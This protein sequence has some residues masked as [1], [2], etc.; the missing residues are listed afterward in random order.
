MPDLKMSSFIYQQAETLGN[1]G[2]VASQ[3]SEKLFQAEAYNEVNTFSPQLQVAASD[4]FDYIKGELGKNNFSL[5]DQKNPLIG[6]KTVG[7][8]VGASSEWYSEQV[9]WIDSNVKNPDARRQLKA[10]LNQRS[11]ELELKVKDEFDNTRIDNIGANLQKSLGDHALSPESL[12]V[13]I[14]KSAADISTAVATNAISATQGEALFQ[15]QRITL[16]NNGLADLQTFIANI[17]NGNATYDQNMATGKL[18]LDEL[19]KNGVDPSKLTILE[20]NLQNIA[21]ETEV[22]NAA[23]DIGMEGGESA[24]VSY[25]YSQTGI[26]NTTKR[27]IKQNAWMAVSDQRTAVGNEFENKYLGQLNEVLNTKDDKGAPLTSSQLYFK[28]K[29]LRQSASKEATA[30]KIPGAYAANMDKVLE[31]RETFYLG[32]MQT[33]N[34]TAFIKEWNPKTSNYLSMLNNGKDD[35]GNIVDPATLADTIERDIQTLEQD[36]TDYGNA[37]PNMEAID[38]LRG[39]QKNAA[40]RAQNNNAAYYAKS[41]TDARLAAQEDVGNALGTIDTALAKL[42]T[43]PH[44]AADPA[45]RENVRAMLSKTK[46]GLLE[47]RTSDEAIGIVNNLY[48]KQ[49]SVQDLIAMGNWNG[50]MTA[51]SALESSMNEAR[52]AGKPL[53]ASVRDNFDKNIATMKELVRQ[54][55]QM[56]PLYDSW[57]SAQEAVELDKDDAGTK[58][59]AF[60]QVIK[61]T[62]W[63]TVG[64]REWADKA[65]LSMKG[66][67]QEKA[68]ARVETTAMENVSQA[69]F[70]AAEAIIANAPDAEEKLKAYSNVIAST[71]WKTPSAKAAAQT[72]YLNMKESVVALKKGTADNATVKA[73]TENDFAYLKLIRGWDDSAD[74]M[75]SISQIDEKLTALE[76]PERG[77]YATDKAAVAILQTLSQLKSDL[78]TRYANQQVISEKDK[79]AAHKRADENKD[80]EVVKFMTQLDK[81]TDVDVAL[82]QV[83]AKIA[84]LSGEGMDGYYD[85]G[86]ASRAVTMLANARET[87]LKKKETQANNAADASILQKYQNFATS[88]DPAIIEEIDS[89]LKRLSSPD[90]WGFTGENA[91]NLAKGWLN[92]LSSLKESKQKSFAGTDQQ[93]AFDAEFTK[94]VTAR[95]IASGGAVTSEDIQG[96]W[97]EAYDTPTEYAGRFYTPSQNVLTDLIGSLDKLNQQ[98]DGNKVFETELIRDISAGKLTRSQALQKVS[99]FIGSAEQVSTTDVN[100]WQDFIDERLPAPA[101]ATIP[102]KPTAETTA[103]FKATV[104]SMLYGGRGKEEIMSFAKPYATMPAFA[105]EYDNV[106][107]MIDGWFKADLSNN[108]LATN[109]LSLIART[110]A[111]DTAMRD[112]VSE[113]FTTMLINGKVENGKTRPYT[114]NEI[115]ELYKTIVDPPIAKSVADFVFLTTGGRAD[116]N[117]GYQPFDYFGGARN[118]ASWAQVMGKDKKGELPVKYDAWQAE[119]QTQLQNLLQTNGTLKQGGQIRLQQDKSGFWWE[120]GD[121]KY[122]PYSDGNGNIGFNA[123]TKL[124]ITDVGSTQGK[125]AQQIKVEQTTENVREILGTKDTPVETAKITQATAKQALAKISGTSFAEVAKNITTSKL[126]LPEKNIL[127]VEAALKFNYNTADLLLEFPSIKEDPVLMQRLS[128]AKAAPAMPATVTASRTTTPGGAR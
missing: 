117:Q 74:I 48:V 1:L 92:S 121:T 63:R 53:D 101:P 76:G 64:E 26:S 70:T 77:G 50:A 81:A 43:D 49:Q 114:D 72:A 120:Y 38:M 118:A 128:Q 106:I 61:E 35:D 122:I 95:I 126:T 25:V 40:L 36:P 89:E 127:A 27:R 90:T 45:G 66:R 22:E 3:F 12:S 104:T 88:E 42:D 100:R 103:N 10:V 31:A 87:L 7:A 34:T 119:A 20:T 8:W 105:D 124:G 47:K 5:D 86:N 68:I 59:D 94:S 79:D 2:N 46:Q 62:P 57:L 52:I 91:S 102:T 75:A 110:W 21:K 112:T 28:V 17:P 93:K 71:A 98:A 51:I 23:I 97:K 84:A 113:K 125:T 78:K 73:N 108:Q 29:D 44:F 123:V 69:Q 96:W 115:E 30:Q 14:E 18:L 82:G 15:Q 56:M 41:D 6:G 16:L 67:L 111:K 13:K 55:V 24:I 85:S 107:K 80:F 83:D 39:I 33:E 32:K 4:R 54:N 11:A 58:L 60:A 19:K 37:S 65:V 109:K 9:K 99:A 116:V